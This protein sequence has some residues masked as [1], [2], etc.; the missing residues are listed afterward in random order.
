MEVSG[1][2]FVTNSLQ[3][4][5]KTIISSISKDGSLRLWDLNGSAYY[6]VYEA[7]GISRRWMYDIVWDPSIQ[8]SNNAQQL[9]YN[10]EGR[11]LSYNM[12]Y[13]DEEF[14]SKKS[15]LIK[16]NTTSV[17]SRHTSCQILVSSING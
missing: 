12:L 11:F 17:A 14:T 7:C 4:G 15:N 1:L 2:E 6:P 9:Q 5:T 13:L 8:T 16:E 10:I 3:Y